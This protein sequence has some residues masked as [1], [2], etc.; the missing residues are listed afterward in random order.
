[1]EKNLDKGTDEGFEDV[2]DEA[3]PIGSIPPF[4]RETDSVLIAPPEDSDEK[5]EEKVLKNFTT[6]KHTFYCCLST[7]IFPQVNTLSQSIHGKAAFPL[8]N[9]PSQYTGELWYV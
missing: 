5:E 1:M 6:L 8:C 4:L 3:A 2:E 7:C 9:P